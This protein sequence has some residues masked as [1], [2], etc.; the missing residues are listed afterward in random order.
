MAKLATRTGG[1]WCQPV[2]APPPLVQTMVDTGPL[3]RPAGGLFYGLG[4]RAARR[5]P[6]LRSVPAAPVYGC[7]RRKLLYPLLRYTT[8][9]CTFGCCSPLRSISGCP[10]PHSLERTKR[11]SC[12]V[13]RAPKATIRLRSNAKIQQPKPEGLAV[14][15]RLH[16]S[17]A[18]ENPV[19]GLVL[20]ATAQQTQSR[21]C[22]PERPG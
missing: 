10:L 12:P 3:A 8:G 14:L 1:T 20:Q 16:F 2:G 22:K 7:R 9:P 15:L 5:R 17:T 21:S 19:A 6:R 11:Y 4:A 13:P 18:C